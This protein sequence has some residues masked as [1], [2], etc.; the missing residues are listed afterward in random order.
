MLNICLPAFHIIISS[1]HCSKLCFQ[2]VLIVKS[3]PSWKRSVVL[4]K[5]GILQNSVSAVH[6][7]QF[8]YTM[9]IMEDMGTEIDSAFVARPGKAVRVVI[10]VEYLNLCAKCCQWI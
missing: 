7:S 1:I 5:N 9:D 6:N 10:I 3:N 4:K 2:L 8:L